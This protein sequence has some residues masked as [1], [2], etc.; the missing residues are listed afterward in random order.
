MTNDCNHYAGG[1]CFIE[2][3]KSKCLGK[4][5]VAYAPRIVRSKEFEDGSYM[6]IY[7]DG[8]IDMKGHIEKSITVSHLREILEDMANGFDEPII[9]DTKV[10][11]IIERVKK[12]L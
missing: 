7:S 9:C 3:K 12:E 10:E 4:N 11:D 1:L 6:R 2:G 8:S 5:C